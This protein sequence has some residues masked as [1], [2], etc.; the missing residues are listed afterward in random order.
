[1]NRDKHGLLT[2]KEDIVEFLL[3][4]KP[5][6]PRAPTG[7]GLDHE[8]YPFILPSFRGITLN[9]QVGD[10]SFGWAGDHVEPR[11][12]CTGNTHKPAEYPN[13]FLQMFACE[14]NQASV[15]SGILNRLLHTGCSSGRIS[16]LRQQ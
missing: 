7:W 4:G 11:V 12:S 15:L 5:G 14:G 8:G 2:N 16:A 6:P 10:N 1:M 13:T 3:E 9:V